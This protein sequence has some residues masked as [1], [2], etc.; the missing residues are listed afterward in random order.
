MQN[1]TEGANAICTKLG[2]TNNKQDA[3]K[4]IHP[5]KR[6]KNLLWLGDHRNKYFILY[7]SESVYTGIKCSS[8]S[9]WSHLFKYLSLCKAQGSEKYDLPVLFLPQ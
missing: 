5:S 8:R 4:A 3:G 7:L 9:P 2:G 6:K 1:A